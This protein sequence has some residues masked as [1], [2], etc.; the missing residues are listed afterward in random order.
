[1][2]DTTLQNPESAAPL[3]VPPPVPVAPRAA[4]ADGDGASRW[5]KTLPLLPVGQAHEALTGQLSLLGSA[6]MPARER[7]KIAEILR[8]QVCHLHTELARRYAGKPQPEGEREREAIDQAISVWH[9]L[10]EQYSTCL[11][12]LLEGDPE[13]AGVK[14]KILQR[15]LFVGKELV[16]VHGLARRA[17]PPETWQELHAYYRLAEMLD[18]AVAAVTDD[19]IPQ[20]VGTSCYSTYSHALLLGLA[21]PCAMTVRQIELADRWLGQW[22]RKLF[23]YARERE[24]ESAVVVVDLDST[25]GARVLAAAPKDAPAAFRFGYPGKLSTSLRG[26]LKRLAGGATPAAMQL[27][28]DVSAE[29]CVAL[30]SHL[31]ARWCHVARA[32]GESEGA[33]LDLV[34]AGLL[35]AFFRIGGRTFERPDPI[36][37][38]FH[39]AQHLKTLGA[40]TDYDRFREEAERDWPWERWSG[41]AEAREATL[42]HADDTR[43]RWGL[44]QLV[45]V[46]N[47][48]RT[49]LGWA[50][51][52]ARAA[53]GEVTLA[54]KLWQGTPRALTLRPQSGAYSDEPPVP[55]LL[56]AEAPDDPPSLIMQPRAFTPGRQLRSID[57][58]GERRF[59]L[60]KLLHRGADF[61]RIA[62]EEAS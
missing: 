15:G 56:L 61:E 62:Y 17:V 2:S 46:R 47:S 21:D 53:N 48:E 35:A 34:S 3:V 55:G 20:G 10:W 42:R 52:V 12:P 23:P 5:A 54:L 8:D 4:F 41:R 26:R 44:D 28:Q 37:R 33:E 13:L 49:R 18:C 11:K 7:A 39:G 29:Q 22:G 59:R 31:E 9:A 6:Q 38:T 32:Q 14:A 51:R 40:L 36:G 43:Y 45:V 60:V 57:G 30:L 25:A 58:G 50:S 19:L 1:M 24:S 27:G 16:L